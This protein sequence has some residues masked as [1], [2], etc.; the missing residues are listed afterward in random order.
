VVL[1]LKLVVEK[2][3][4]FENGGELLQILSAVV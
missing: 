1:E 4:A 2:T 3:T